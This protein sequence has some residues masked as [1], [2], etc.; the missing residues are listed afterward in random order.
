MR[1][2]KLALAAAL[3]AAGSH[4][5]ADIQL[6]NN[7]ELVLIVWSPTAVKKSYVLDLGLTYDTVMSTFST[8]GTLYSK[9]ISDATLTATGLI[10]ASDTRWAVATMD[11]VG[12]PAPDNSGMDNLSILTTVRTGSAFSAANPGMT[13]DGLQNAGSWADWISLINNTGTNASGSASR[14]GQGARVPSDTAIFSMTSRVAGV[15]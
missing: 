12:D 1:F 11:T 2:M 8:A 15:T 10:G 9:P 3:V 14:I 7:P 6:G 5:S 13:N 4:A